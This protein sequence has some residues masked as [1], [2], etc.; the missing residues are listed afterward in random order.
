VIA[1]R[2]ALRR[3][4]SPKVLNFHSYQADEEYDHTH[5]WLV[6]QYDRPHV[7]SKPSEGSLRKGGLNENSILSKRV[8]FSMT[9]NFHLSAR[10]LLRWECGV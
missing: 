3:R 8:G 6:V 2:F 10:R 7:K 5:P 1:L 9:E 4:L